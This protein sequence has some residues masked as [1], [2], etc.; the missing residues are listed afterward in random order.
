M[1]TDFRYIAPSGKGARFIC[2]CILLDHGINKGS[3][4]LQILSCCGFVVQQFADFLICVDNC[5]SILSNCQEKIASSIYFSFHVQFHQPTT[6]SRFKMIIEM[7]FSKQHTED[8]ISDGKQILNDFANH[9]NEGRFI[10]DGT[11]SFLYT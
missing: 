2:R 10:S 7:T 8:L 4:K 11:K 3:Q 5:Y 6:L 9:T 1:I